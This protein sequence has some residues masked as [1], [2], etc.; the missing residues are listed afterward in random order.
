MITTIT[1]TALLIAL[2]I[3]LTYRI[4]SIKKRKSTN[5]KIV[6]SRAKDPHDMYYR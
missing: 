5:E 6:A 1:V 4:L 2:L 3:A